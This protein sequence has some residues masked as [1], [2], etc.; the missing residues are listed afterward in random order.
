[1]LASLPLGAMEILDDPA[2]SGVLTIRD[3]DINILSYC[4]GDQ[5]QAGVDEKY[6]RSSYIHPVWSLDG[7]TV[8][9]DDFP[10]D[11]PHHR[12]IYWA[13]PRVETRGVKTE[14]WHPADPPLR[15]HFVR[16]LSR[17][18]DETSASFT[19][20]NRW[21]LDNKEEVASEKV[22]VQV[23]PISQDQRAIDIE[24]RLTAVGGPLKLAGSPQ[25]NKGYGGFCYRATPSFKGARILTSFGAAEQDIVNQ[26]AAW[27]SLSTNNHGVAFFAWPDNPE[28][29]PN[30]MARNSYAGFANASW[31]GLSPVELKPD[32]SVTLRYRMLI[33]NGR[34]TMDKVSAVYEEYVSNRLAD[35]DESTGP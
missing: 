26:P 32:E 3:G 4:Y 27:V 35:K 21:L 29:P 6:T 5:L 23:H 8:L 16:W 30:W 2:S 18:A 17:D 28:Y 7:K 19:V 1:M 22:T 34:A 15:Q 25:D 20:E 14:N 9:T 12:G 13:W 31:P 11:H 10:D 24:V 33:H